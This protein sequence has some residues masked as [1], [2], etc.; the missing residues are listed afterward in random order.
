MELM[1]SVYCHD[2]WQWKQLLYSKII[3]KI[4]VIVSTTMTNWHICRVRITVEQTNIN[5]SSECVNVMRVYTHINLSS[6]PDG[7]SF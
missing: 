3:E 4:I 2:D 7:S 1:P 6:N 5:N